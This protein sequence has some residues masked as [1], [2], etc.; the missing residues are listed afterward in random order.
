[1][2]GAIRY[3]S[4]NHFLPQGQSATTGMLTSREKQCD[5]NLEWRNKVGPQWADKAQ[6][7]GQHSTGKMI[8]TQCSLE[9]G[10]IT[11]QTSL[12]EVKSV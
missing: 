10:P 4:L 6:E 5:G 1:M 12:K 11:S 7:E 2:P 8:T 9:A 3:I